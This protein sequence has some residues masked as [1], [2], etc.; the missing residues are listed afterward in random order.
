MYEK[1]SKACSGDRIKMA[2][3]KRATADSSLIPAA[4]ETNSF[5]IMFLFLH[6]VHRYI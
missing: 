1:V 5:R 6:G 2:A 3:G 4:F